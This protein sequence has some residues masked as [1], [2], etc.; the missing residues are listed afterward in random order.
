MIPVTNKKS[1][2][3]DIYKSFGISNIENWESGNQA[4]S[5]ND[6]DQALADMQSAIGLGDTSVQQEPEMDPYIQQQQEFDQAVAGANLEV[7]PIVQ[8]ISKSMGMNVGI[9]DYQNQDVMPN[10]MTNASDMVNQKLQSIF[11]D[12]KQQRFNPTGPIKITEEEWKGAKYW[13]ENNQIFDQNT[14][15]VRNDIKRI[16][17]D[18]LQSDPNNP[19]SIFAKSALAL[20]AAVEADPSGLAEIFQYMVGDKAQ[21]YLTPEND[22]YMQTE[23]GMTFGFKSADML[24]TFGWISQILPAAR[25][26]ALMAK[27]QV[28]LLKRMV[29][30][31]LIEG[32][33]SAGMEA[34]SVGLGKS[35]FDM[36]DPLLATAFGAVGEGGGAIFDKI[37]NYL[38]KSVVLENGVRKNSARPIYK[39]ADK[40]LFVDMYQKMIDKEMAIK[41]SGVMP[42]AIMPTDQNLMDTVFAQPENARRLF[43]MLADNYD[44]SFNNL[45]DYTNKLA[46]MEFVDTVALQGNKPA[47]QIIKDMYD[48][49]TGEFKKGLMNATKDMAPIDVE[50]LLNGYLKTINSSDDIAGKQAAKKNIEIL[51]KSIGFKDKVITNTIPKGYDPLTNKA[52][53]ETV[54]E[55]TP[56]MTLKNGDQVQG[57]REWLT[58]RKQQLSNKFESGDYT[59]T[60]NKERLFLNDFVSEFD[61][62]ISRNLGSDEYSEVLQAYITAS[63]AIK[64]VKG[65]VIGKI[66]SGEP[67]IADEIVDALVYPQNFS[68]KRQMMLTLSLMGQLT[69]EA[70]QTVSKHL[71]LR[72][73][74][75]AKEVMDKTVRLKS[76]R[77]GFEASV[78]SAKVPNIMLNDVFNNDVFNAVKVLGKD[79]PGFLQKYQAAKRAFEHMGIESEV[80]LHSASK[81]G[82]SRAAEEIALRK[83]STAMAG[84]STG[85][86]SKFLPP[87]V[88][89]LWTDLSKKKRSY[90]LIEALT[91]PKKMK[92]FSVILNALRNPTNSTLARAMIKTLDDIA[93]E[94][95]EN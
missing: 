74:Q 72:Q 67:L 5:Q 90:A 29:Y 84:S 36:T 20:G 17:P 25:I 46:A 12:I 32:G 47:R 22:L 89:Q 28:P 33:L 86:A 51:F 55:R 93:L 68:D 8:T 34:T 57:M 81:V 83:G 41:G 58:N 69:P 88:G 27:A 15:L 50:P 26:S 85:G 9:D 14:G 48:E 95:E 70:K 19:L 94:Y 18:I 65:G 62:F 39:S 38:K 30:S 43:S 60:E 75:K 37:A 16:I 45:Y 87:F 66:A 42:A 64:Q 63:H 56:D 61:D 1:R 2:E 73:M 59:P 11:T 31:G 91:N 54:T 21:V 79:N 44:K 92:D 82:S 13:N 10:D 35:E 6:I 4:Y 52:I 78:N 23:E 7:S 49:A 53:Y 77:E 80:A 76:M 24:N 40:D 3:D 71:L